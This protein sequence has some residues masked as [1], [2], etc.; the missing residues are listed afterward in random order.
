MPYQN[1]RIK[2]KVKVGEKYGVI[3]ECGD[4]YKV[5]F[6]DGDFGFYA[7][8]EVTPIVLESETKGN[9]K[10]NRMKAESEKLPGESFMQPTATGTDPLAQPVNDT[11]SGVGEP[12]NVLGKEVAIDKIS[13]VFKYQETN[14][15]N[16]MAKKK[17]L[18]E[19]PASEEEVEKQDSD[20]DS[21][22]EKKKKSKKEAEEE[23]T[24][25]QKSHR[26]GKK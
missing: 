5:K 11:G 8:T 22:E 17:V 14:G 21:E 1:L 19:D 16:Q 12:Q 26:G 6:D 13:R 9:K 3:M 2:Q 25:K 4:K 7:G 20:D 10:Y 15:G 23:D 18:E 24:E